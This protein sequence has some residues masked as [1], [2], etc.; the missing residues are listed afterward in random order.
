MI[1]R[2]TLISD[3]IDHFIREI[4]IDSQAS[5]L[6]F[7]KAILASVGYPND[8]MTSFFL[9]GEDWEKETEITLEDMGGSSDE[10]TWVM[11]STP[12]NELV[13]DEHQHLLY[14]FDPLADRVFFI[15]LSE[16]ITGKTLASPICTKKVGEAPQQLLDFDQLM[17]MNTTTSS[18]DLDDS[19][20]DDQGFDLDELDPEGMDFIDDSFSTGGGSDLF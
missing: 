4:Q 3:E 17:N 5:F 18:L 6:D 10:D 20:S 8:Q 13:E 19:F 12:L 1:Y 14:V 15:E 7:H 11:E 9:C 2:F 16:I